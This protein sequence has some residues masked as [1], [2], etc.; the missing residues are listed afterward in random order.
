MARRPG[1]VRDAIIGYLRTHKGEAKVSDIHMAVERQLGGEVPRSSVRSY[2][3]LN[4]GSGK[5]FEST[6]RG[7]YRLR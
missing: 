4:S 7:H 6:G 3:R 5:T 2:L 1:E